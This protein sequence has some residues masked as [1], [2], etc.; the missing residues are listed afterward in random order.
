MQAGI[1][2]CRPVPASAAT[3]AGAA[4]LRSPGGGR[5][6]GLPARGSLPP[7]RA[8]P[9]LM[10]ASNGC[11]ITCGQQIAVAVLQL[12]LPRCWHDRGSQGSGCCCQ[13]HRHG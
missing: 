12:S 9:A 13:Q 4:R 5:G 1:G 3:V 8:C 6:R 7:A 2:S 11:G 10:R